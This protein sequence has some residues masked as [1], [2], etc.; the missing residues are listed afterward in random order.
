MRELLVHKYRR[1]DVFYSIHV[2]IDDPEIALNQQQGD[3]SL[4]RID[5]AHFVNEP[6]PVPAIQ[7]PPAGSRKPRL[8]F[9]SP[10]SSCGM[11]S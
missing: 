6:T 7:V 9:E 3:Y 1:Q 4:S 11:V 5:P 2:Y 10:P 8:G